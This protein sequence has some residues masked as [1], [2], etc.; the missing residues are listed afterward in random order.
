MAVFVIKS[1]PDFGF[2]F[3]ETRIR[4]F[5][6][7]AHNYVGHG[8]DP[9]PILFWRTNPVKLNP[10]PQLCWSWFG[11]G[12]CYKRMFNSSDGVGAIVHMLDG[13]SEIG[14]HVR[15]NWLDREQL[16]IGFFCS[17]MAYFPSNVRN[18]F[19]VTSLYKY[20]GAEVALP[21]PVF[22]KSTKNSRHAKKQQKHVAKLHSF[23]WFFLL[24]IT[25]EKRF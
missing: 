5:W 1:D 23:P 4:S 19:W 22:L 2:F 21:P 25:N 8:S 16:Q 13:N 15:R 3:L 9:D 12:S 18:M 14:A 6:N 24:M 7:R 10:D 11:S 17:E 20:H